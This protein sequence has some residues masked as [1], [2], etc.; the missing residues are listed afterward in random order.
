VDR[1]ARR[2]RPGP[3]D[4]LIRFETFGGGAAQARHFTTPEEFPGGEVE[5]LLFDRP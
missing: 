1:P 3:P 5:V 4:R 2:F